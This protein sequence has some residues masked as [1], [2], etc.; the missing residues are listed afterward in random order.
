MGVNFY[1]GQRDINKNT[2]TLLKS[3]R[4]CLARGLRLLSVIPYTKWLQIL[5]LVWEHTYILGSV[6]VQH[7]QK[8][9]NQ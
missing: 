3:C 1:K 6:L 9:A 5:S 2:T 7:L 4:T 8:A